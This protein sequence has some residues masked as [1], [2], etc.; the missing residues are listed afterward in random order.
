MF[1]HITASFISVQASDLSY[2]TFIEASVTQRQWSGNLK[3]FVDDKI[4]VHT[5]KIKG[6]VDDYVFYE[7]AHD[8]KQTCAVWDLV[9]AIKAHLGQ[10]SVPAKKY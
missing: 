7:C 10:H 6:H 5:N 8:N 3:R 4:P 2:M 1:S 9:F